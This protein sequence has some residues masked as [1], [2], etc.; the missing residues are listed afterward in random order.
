MCRLREDFEPQRLE[1]TKLHEGI[2]CESLRLTAFVV[3]NQAT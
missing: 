2:L 3:L 1:D